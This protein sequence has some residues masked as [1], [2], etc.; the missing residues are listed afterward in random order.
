MLNSP[1]SSPSAPD[2][3]LL[4]PVLC[5]H[6]CPLLLSYFSCKCNICWGKFTN[7]IFLPA[8]QNTY[9]FTTQ[10]IWLSHNSSR[11]SF[12][13]EN[14]LLRIPLPSVYITSNVTFQCLQ[15]SLGVCQLSRPKKKK[16]SVSLLFFHQYIWHH[17]WRT[18]KRHTV[19]QTDLDKMLL[20]VPHEHRSI[21]KQRKP[22]H[23]SPG[24]D[25]L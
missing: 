6:L 13:E 16:K 22:L 18:N 5:S 14:W 12:S 9:Y 4:L 8:T 21:F 24:T 17:L 15:C 7:P 23:D 20:F 2:G 1:D 25:F 3:L 19:K 10:P 11:S